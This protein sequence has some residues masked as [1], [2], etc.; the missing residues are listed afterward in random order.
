M[1]SFNFNQDGYLDK[2]LH[3][4]KELKERYQREEYLLH[5]KFF[6]D[7]RTFVDDN[8]DKFIVVNDHY[9]IMV[10]DKMETLFPGHGSRGVI[11][12]FFIEGVVIDTDAKIF[13][14]AF[15]GT[16]KISMTDIL[17]ETTRDAFY[18]ALSVMT[19][20]VLDDKNEVDFI[21]DALEYGYPVNAVQ[22][23]KDYPRLFSDELREYALNIETSEEV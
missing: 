14:D 3:E 10:K 23:I 13:K 17:K 11:S 18:N 4:I 20:R 12:S 1:E 7:L 2:R 16:L 9:Y 5:L 15:R 6:R 8:M 21:K 22:V 19:R